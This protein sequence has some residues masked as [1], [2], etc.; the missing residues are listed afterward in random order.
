M[1]E[2]KLPELGENIHEA[3]VIRLLVKEGD[4]I[5]ADQNVMEV[6]SEKAA[7]PLPCPVAG[8]VSKILVKEGDT[9]KVGQALLN[10]EDSAVPSAEARETRDGGQ[11]ARDES[12]ETREQQRP[13]SRP[14]PVDPR[15]ST[16]PPIPAGPATRRL[17]RELH[18]QLE[19]LKGTGPGGRITPEDVK[20]VAEQRPSGAEAGTDRQRPARQGDAPSLPDFSRWGSVRRQ[21]LN[22]LGRTSAERLSLAWRMI[23]HVTQHEWAD[24]T[25]LETAR[26]NYEGQRQRE[27][28]PK[29]TITALAI[30]AVTAA[31]HAF[32]QFNA[33]LDPASGELIVKQYCHIGV[34]V[35]TEDGLLVPVIRD[36]DRKS[37]AALAVELANLADKARRR[38]LTVEEMQGGTF[39]ITNL[40]GIG[41]GPFTPI[42]NYPEV[43]IL[44]LA[45]SRWQRVPRGRRGRGDNRLLLPLSLSYDHRVIN[46]AWGA[47]FLTKITELLSE[48]FL[49]LSEI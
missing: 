47:R 12:R 17:A 26:E 5:K 33:S 19:A 15:P 34:A 9:I 28:Q 39:T 35:D 13:A 25:E 44:G 20:K 1:A 8:R 30:K 22:K 48:P 14:S 21:P 2:F 41:G 18:V 31:L 46:G 27:T 36:A 24:I 37:V 49:L 40:G 43:A 45:R 7:A 6:E 10:I 23:P 32:P 29:I 4:Q 38:Q 16:Q 11:Q 3:E 42:I